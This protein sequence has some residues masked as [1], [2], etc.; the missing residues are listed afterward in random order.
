MKINKILF[1]ATLLITFASYAQIDKGNCMMGVSGG[2]SNYKTKFNGFSSE[3][4]NI[5]ITPNV[6]CFENEE[7]PIKS[8]L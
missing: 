4:T 3:G 6:G 5:Y 1:I 2:I 8:V 7:L